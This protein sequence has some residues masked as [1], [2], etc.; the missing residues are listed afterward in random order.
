MNELLPLI[1]VEGKDY[2]G[3][4]ARIRGKVRDVASVEDGAQKIIARVRRG[5][6]EALEEL[7][8]SLDNSEIGGRIRVQEDEVARAVERV[9]AE[10]ARCHEIHL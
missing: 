8:T 4:A 1:K 2:P 5:G 6:D 3:A 7:T 10:A 9:D